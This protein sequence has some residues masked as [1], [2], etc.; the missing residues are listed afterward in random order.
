VSDVR[1]IGLGPVIQ[2]CPYVG[3]PILLLSQIHFGSGEEHGFAAVGAVASFDIQVIA[4][5]AQ[6]DGCFQSSAGEVFAQSNSGSFFRLNIQQLADVLH[7]V[8]LFANFD[9]L[10]H[11]RI[12]LFCESSQSRLSDIMQMR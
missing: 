8:D 11:N 2:E 5:A 10:I 1:H 4:R 3:L 9:E 6:E 12:L 7:R